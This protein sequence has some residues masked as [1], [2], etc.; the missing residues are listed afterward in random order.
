MLDG[1]CELLRGHMSFSPNLQ[2]V[3]ENVKGWSWVWP[4]CYPLAVK[5]VHFGLEIGWWVVEVLSD[6]RLLKKLWQVQLFKYLGQETVIIAGRPWFMVL[7]AG[8]EQWQLSTKNISVLPLSRLRKGREKIIVHFRLRTSAF[9][10]VRD[11]LHSWKLSCWW[12]LYK[13]D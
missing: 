1:E 3:F 4:K 8:Q 7:P 6:P 9:S 11:P 2:G 5:G 12:H 13:W 10:K